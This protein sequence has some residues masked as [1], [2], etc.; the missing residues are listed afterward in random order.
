M[1]KQRFGCLKGKPV[2]LMDKAT[3]ELKLKNGQ[4][5]IQSLN[6]GDTAIVKRSQIKKVNY[7]YPE[8]KNKC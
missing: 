8:K 7:K 4:I 2:Y 3:K 5:L 1:E 6:S